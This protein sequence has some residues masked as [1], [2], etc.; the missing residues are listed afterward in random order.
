MPRYAPVQIAFTD[1][2][3]NQRRKNVVQSDITLASPYGSGLTLTDPDLTVDIEDGVTVTV[4]ENCSWIIVDMPE[5][6]YPSEK[7]RW[8]FISY[9]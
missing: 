9:K 8:Q 5:G 1:N 3:F 7:E 4:D 2:V 6:K